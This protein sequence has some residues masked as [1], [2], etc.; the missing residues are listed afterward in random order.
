MPIRRN[1]WALGTFRIAMQSP[2]PLRQRVVSRLRFA[3]VF[4]ETSAGFA[5]EHL[6]VAQPK[7]DRGNVIAPPVRLLKCVANIDCDIDANF[8][9][10]S[11]WAHR[12]TPLQKRIVDLTSVYTALEKSPRINQT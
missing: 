7:Q 3:F 2:S 6:P 8:V 9:D 10:Q 12:H 1:G 5:T 11:Q 4:V